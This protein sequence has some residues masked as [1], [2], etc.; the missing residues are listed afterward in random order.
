MHPLRTHSTRRIDYDKNNVKTNLFTENLRVNYVPT[1]LAIDSFNTDII[2][3]QYE[4][5]LTGWR[6][7]YGG[8][9][10]YW[11]TRP[12]QPLQLPTLPGKFP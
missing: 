2:L 1:K 10:L 9:M 4:R 11:F 3:P 12:P 8:W 7:W 6:D 5:Y